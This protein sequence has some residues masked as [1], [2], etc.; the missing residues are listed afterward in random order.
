LLIDCSPGIGLENKYAIGFIDQKGIMVGLLDAVNGYPKPGIWFIGLLLFSPDHR[1]KGLGKKALNG[2]EE[3]ILSQ[4]LL[5]FV[6]VW[7]RK[8]KQLF[9]FGKRWGSTYWKNDRLQN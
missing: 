2:F 4:G 7:W 8:T 9:D 5:R 6:W 1:K 3:W